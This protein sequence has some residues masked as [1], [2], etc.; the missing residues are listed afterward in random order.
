MPYAP[1]H[2][3]EKQREWRR[4]HPHYLRK[5]RK[6]NPGKQAE[7]DAQKDPVKVNARN[8]LNKAVASGKIERP[9]TCSMCGGSEKIQAHHDDYTKPLEVVWLCFDCHNITYHPERVIS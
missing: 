6:A 2:R 7:Y 4:A 1:H 5:W 3:A 8:K 9:D